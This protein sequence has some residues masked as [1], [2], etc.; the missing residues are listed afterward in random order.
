MKQKCLIK[1]DPESSNDRPLGIYHPIRGDGLAGE[2][3]TR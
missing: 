3:R 1:R 2:Y